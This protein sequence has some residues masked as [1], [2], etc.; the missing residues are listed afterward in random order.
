MVP[1][2]PCSGVS[3]RSP[4]DVPN[5]LKNLVLKPNIKI[6]PGRSAAI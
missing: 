1:R 3:G 4:E 5:F 6:K 2:S